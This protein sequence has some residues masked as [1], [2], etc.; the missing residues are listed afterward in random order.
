[1]VAERVADLLPTTP[2][3]RS[4][5]ANKVVS[6]YDAICAKLCVPGPMNNGMV[7]VIVNGVKVHDKTFVPLTP[8]PLNKN[9][10]SLAMMGK[11]VK[12]DDATLNLPHAVLL[13]SLDLNI[14]FVRSFSRSNPF[15]AS[16]TRS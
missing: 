5:V 3:S 4:N 1:M 9:T 7:K 8:V 12:D 6:V 15:G 14:E 16:V 10:F 11:S 13:N 2:L